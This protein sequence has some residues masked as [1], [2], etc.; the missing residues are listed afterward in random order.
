[1]YIFAH[2]RICREQLKQSSNEKEVSKAWAS[3]KAPPLLCYS[4]VTKRSRSITYLDEIL[5][6]LRSPLNQS[7]DGTD[8][9]GRSNFRSFQSRERHFVMS[10]CIDA[11]AWLKIVNP[12]Y[13]VDFIFFALWIFFI[14][15]ILSLDITSSSYYR[16]TYF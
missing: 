7:A 13:D 5:M 16:K 10:T 3:S 9:S 12:L 15:S 8:L 4:K 6:P 2:S 11:V 1:M 14:V